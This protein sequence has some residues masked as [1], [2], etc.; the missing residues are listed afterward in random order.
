MNGIATVRN[1]SG[2]VLMGNMNGIADISNM[3]LSPMISICRR[4]ITNTTVKNDMSGMSRSAM[5][6]HTSGR[7]SL[8]TS[9]VSRLRIFILFDVFKQSFS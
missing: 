2:S 3:S 1:I 9:L 6:S 8:F 5:I 7:H 4:A